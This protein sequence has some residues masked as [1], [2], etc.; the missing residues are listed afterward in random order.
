MKIGRF[1]IMVLSKNLKLSLSFFLIALISCFFSDF[2]I[3]SLE[4]LLELKKFSSAIFKINLLNIPS[5]LDA[6]LRT[7]FIAVLAIFFSSII[8]FILA[9]FYNSVILRSILAFI[10][11]IHEIF[12]ALIFLQIFGL[13][14]LT[15]L[16]ALVLPFSSILAKVYSEI[17]EEHDV[18]D[19][20]LRGK[21]SISYYFYTKIPD[22][23]PHL[24]SY[25]LYRFECAL[26]SSAI[27]GFVGITTL[28]YYLSSSFNQGIYEDVWLLLIMFYILIASIK[29][30]FNKYSFLFLIIASFV[31]LGDFGNLNLEH[32][33][34]FFTS[35]IIPYPIKNNLSSSDTY[36]WFYKLFVNEIVPGVF[37][38]I[39][40]TQIALVL[41]AIL[42][43]LAFPFITYKFSNKYVRFLAHIILVVLRS[44]PEY[45][46]AYLFL[47]IF[48]PSFLPAALALMLHNGSIIA[49][50][51]GKQSNELEYGIDSTKK[52][53]SL[54]AYETLPRIYSSFLAF[55][56]YRWEI[57]MRESAILGILG[58]S[59]LGFYIDSAIADFRLDKMMLLLLVTALLNILIDII[60]R[61]ARAYLKV[62][63]TS[64]SCA[65]TLK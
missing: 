53:I 60:S 13:T 14:V 49:F 37:N 6:L 34:R 20:S 21:N 11:A 31:Y 39:L 3:S 57:I 10:R 18:F 43:L 36:L 55:L 51:M 58:V 8:G 27:L 25:T 7:V 50:L 45:I 35:D 62:K 26:R 63:T 47:Q 5:L 30:W 46:L 48:G 41:T 9:L 2:S 28:G 56:F 17:L 22:A 33:I 23:F 64:T 24:L 16:L 32:F 12:W 61:R 52:K 40:L 19:I 29:L 59:T 4:P 15:A 65:G 44:S 1:C 38:T 54:Y 42:A